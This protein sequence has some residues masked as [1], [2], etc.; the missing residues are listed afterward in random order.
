[1]DGDAFLTKH[2]FIFYT[3]G[4]EHPPERVTAF[5]KYIPTRLQP[6]FPLLFLLRH[7]K[8]G[9]IRLVRLEKLYSA[10]NFQ[11]LTEIFRKDFPEFVHFCPFRQKELISPPKSLIKKIY[12]PSQCLQGLFK[13]RKHDPLQKQALEI[14]SL[15]SEESGVPLVDFGLHGSVAL[16]MHSVESDIDLVVYGGENFRRVEAAVNQLLASTRRNRGEYGGKVFVFNAVRKPDEINV[17]Y[18]DYRYLSISPVVFRC[19]VEDDTEAIFRPALYRIGDYQPLNVASQLEKIET[20]KT[21]VSMVGYFR[22]VAR[23]GERIEVSGMLEQVEHVKTGRVAYQVVVGSAINKE[24]YI[25]K[26]SD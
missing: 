17:V 16:D 11:K 4:Y 13:K 15:L 24:E 20:P 14:V 12:V 2:N 7:W 18:G 6:H 1:M 9:S 19:R 21:V 8:W 23:R 25:W 26:V 5:L 10:K 3:F 22:N